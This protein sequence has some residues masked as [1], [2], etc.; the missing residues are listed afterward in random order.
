[1][2]E[3]TVTLAGW[4][5]ALGAPPPE[6]LLA[7]Q[8]HGAEQTQ[9]LAYLE[10]AEI[11]ELCAALPP[12]LQSQ[13]RRGL[14]TLRVAAGVEEA[15]EPEPEPELRRPAPTAQR[16]TAGEVEQHAAVLQAYTPGAGEG[17]ADAATRSLH[18]CWR[19]CVADPTLRQRLLPL[20][21]TIAKRSDAGPVEKEAALALT[22]LAFSLTGTV[23]RSDPPDAAPAAPSAVVIIIGWLGSGIAD[24]ADVAQH[25]RAK[26][27]GC[28]VLTTVGGSDRWADAADPASLAED[29][30]GS[31]PLFAVRS[32]S[33]SLQ[34]WLESAHRCLKRWGCAGGFNAGVAD[35][36]P[37]RGAPLA[38]GRGDAAARR[39][40]RASAARD[41][42][43]TVESALG[44]VC[45]SLSDT[46]T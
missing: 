37:V 43:P 9:D 28:K 39:S 21:F 15:A 24:F 23:I 11:D 2:A 19:A 26:C 8:A 31:A 34:L 35:G 32:R 12:L 38:A 4:V 46:Q 1:M 44:I 40:Q 29:A 16:L 10:A 14:R 22:F 41:V 7:L 25:Y 33:G 3:D 36:R 27:P 18:A 20:L 45:A 13:L 6:L 30:P 17:E 42:R 5:A